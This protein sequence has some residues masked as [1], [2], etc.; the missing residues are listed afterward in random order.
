MNDEV[1]HAPVRHENSEIID[2]LR[3]LSREYKKEERVKL[4]DYLTEWANDFPDNKDVVDIIRV[5]IEQNNDVKVFG[6]NYVCEKLFKNPN[7]QLEY[8]MSRLLDEEEWEKLNNRIES[9]DI[10]ESILLQAKIYYSMEEA[11][12]TNNKGRHHSL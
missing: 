8:F 7:N 4:I 5:R 6:F 12:K 3:Y 9:R 11:A 1:N 10:K 2:G